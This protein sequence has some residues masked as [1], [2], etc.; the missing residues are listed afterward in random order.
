ML[1]REK[2]AFN[3]VSWKAT[4]IL[5]QSEAEEKQAEPAPAETWIPWR[6]SSWQTWKPD[7]R[8]KVNMVKDWVDGDSFQEAPVWLRMFPVPVCGRSDWAERK[9]F[10][11]YP[12]N[13]SMQTLQNYLVLIRVTHQ[14]C[15]HTTGPHTLGER[16]RPCASSI[17]MSALMI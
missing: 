8:S 6:W 7:K 5:L 3:K 16:F 17:C 9:V 10:K 11:S 14:E 2:P 4:P 13:P 12:S 15:F 1:E